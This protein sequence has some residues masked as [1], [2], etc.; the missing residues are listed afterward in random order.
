MANIPNNIG[1]SRDETVFV[2]L[3]STK[4]TLV[5]PLS[6][7]VEAVVCAGDSEIGQDPTFTDSPEKS[8]SRDVLNQFQDMIP[9]G[10][11]KIPLCVRPSGTAGNVPMGDALL[12]S[13]FGKKT[14]N[15]GVSVVYSQALTKPSVSIWRKRGHT[16]RFCAGAVVDS[17]TVKGV[18]KGAVI[19]EMSGQFMRMGWAGTDQ[20]NAAAAQAAT[21]FT[22]KNAK[23]FT[24]GAVIWNKTKNDKATNGYTITGV[25]TTTNAIT[26]TPAIV[27]AGG[28]AV[29]D[30][31]EGYL[32]TPAPIGAA[33]ESR[34]STISVL[35]AQ[36]TLVELNVT[37]GDKVQV[38]D[39][40][41]TSSGYPEDY[42]EDTR[43]IKGNIK[44]N[45]RRLD[46]ALFTD[47]LAGSEGAVNAQFGT[48]AGKIATLNFARAKMAVP[49]ESSSG[50]LTQLD[51]AFTAL[52]TNG[53][54]SAT[55]T[56]T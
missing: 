25:N 13:V 11:F 4:G 14:V 39:N 56:F 33:L 9:A 41:M 16:V 26:F 40:E 21:T 27:P 50:P 37:Y 7:G 10:Q 35:G 6:T 12:L 48:V 54:D 51:V 19:L 20:V 8:G 17:F 31:I 46:V 3:E 28:W 15:A 18:N 47:G 36:K 44:M 49:R 5:F 45:F 43:S 53:E 38:L 2:V 34:K 22:A 52:G 23:L 1:T 32:P 55:F 30:Q 29:D 24:V 42:V